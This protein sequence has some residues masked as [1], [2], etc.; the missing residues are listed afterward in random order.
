MFDVLAQWF[1]TG[2][3]LTPRG[4]KSLDTLLAITNERMLMAFSE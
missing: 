4:Q 3:N 2:L 1:S